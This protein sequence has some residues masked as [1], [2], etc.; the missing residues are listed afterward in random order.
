MRNHHDRVA[1]RDAEQG[2]EPDRRAKPDIAYRI[3]E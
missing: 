3:N 1:E 2:H